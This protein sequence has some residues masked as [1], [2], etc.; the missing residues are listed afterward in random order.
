[1]IKVKSRFISG[2][3]QRSTRRDPRVLLCIDL[4]PQGG[5]SSYAPLINIRLVRCMSMYH[6]KEVE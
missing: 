1:V 6:K 3:V 5:L 4:G 2:G